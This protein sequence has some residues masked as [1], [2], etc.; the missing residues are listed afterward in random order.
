MYSIKYYLSVRNMF[1]MIPTPEEPPIYQ[2]LFGKMKTTNK[3]SIS[4]TRRHIRR[5][6]STERCF[7][8]NAKHAFSPQHWTP[9]RAPG[10]NRITNKIL[11]NH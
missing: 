7:Q 8:N 1:E 6:H 11:Q 9:S 2:H 3:N 4:T 5:C 10:T